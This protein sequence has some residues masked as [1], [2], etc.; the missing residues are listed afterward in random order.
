MEDKKQVPAEK[1]PLTNIQVKPSDAKQKE[2]FEKMADEF[3]AASGQNVKSAFIDYLLTL[4]E[5]DGIKSGLSEANRTNVESFQ[6]HI[7]R[8]NQLFM[9]MVSS[10]EDSDLKAEERVRRILESKDQT[11]L[12]LQDKLLVAEQVK[13][14]CTLQAKQLTDANNAIQIEYNQYKTNAQHKIET[15]ENNLKEKTDMTNDLSTDKRELREKVSGMED[16]CARYDGL[17]AEVSSYKK[18]VEE[19]ELKI[20]Q[21]KNEILI[22]NSKLEQQQVQFDKEKE[23]LVGLMKKQHEAEIR[24]QIANV[25][26]EYLAKMEKAQ[27]ENEETIKNLQTDY[28]EISKEY[29]QY[30]KNTE[31]QNSSK[32]K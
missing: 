3:L 31:L 22:L 19:L 16:K 21:D 12:G 4:A 7:A 27:K 17:V 13:E 8:L 23:N 18:Q 30:R 2:R 26:E 20:N 9:L 1:K 5:E 28:Q 32:S 10:V 11:I 24:E 6:M 29:N 14:Q 15:L 25:K